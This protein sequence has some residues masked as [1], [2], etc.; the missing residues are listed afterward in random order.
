MEGIGA[1]QLG[2]IL[3]NTID[4]L[5]AELSDQHFD[6]GGKQPRKSACFLQVQDWRIGCELTVGEC[7]LALHRQSAT[8]VEGL[9]RFSDPVAEKKPTQNRPE[10]IVPSPRMIDPEKSRPNPPA[11]GLTRAYV[12]IKHLGVEMPSGG[13]V[14]Q[15]DG[16]PSVG[17][18]YRRP[19]LKVLKAQIAPWFG[20]PFP[21]S[22][23]LPSAAG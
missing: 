16:K 18:P 10:P 7:I 22:R 12:D 1:G 23:T 11:L 6:L 20:R 4:C 5:T 19:G 17:P 2:L 9:D 14:P 15:V 3:G 21:H 8:E 13:G